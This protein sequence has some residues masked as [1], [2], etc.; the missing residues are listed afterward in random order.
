MRISN[1]VF[2]NP[3]FSNVLAILVGV[4]SQVFCMVYTMLM[5]C[6]IFYSN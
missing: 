4:G 5:L 6:F 3:E 1:D 2:R